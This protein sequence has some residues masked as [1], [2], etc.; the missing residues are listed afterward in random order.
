METWEVVLILVLVTIAVSVLVKNDISVSLIDTL[1]N[2]I[3]QLAILATT[4]LLATVSPAVAIVAI[5]TIVVVYYVRNLAKIQMIEP[6][7]D[8]PRIELTEVKTVTMVGTPQINIVEST[9]PEVSKGTL[10]QSNKAPPAD[11]SDVITTVLGEHVSRPPQEQK[12][13]GERAKLGGAAPFESQP[14]PAHERFENPRGEG[15]IAEA[16]DKQAEFYGDAPIHVDG[17]LG[18]VDSDVFI[19]APAT[20]D[21]FNEALIAPEVRPYNDNQGQY[22]IGETRP[23]TK[24]Q[25][26]ELASFQPGSEMGSNDFSPV[27]VSID[28]K[29]ANMNSAFMPSATAPPNFNNAVPGRA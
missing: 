24:V 1:D 21:G 4:L 2:T 13:I 22:T 8:E 15:F 6:T 16:L 3:F 28:D 5:A 7:S 27:G 12:L 9:P 25:K 11:N 26:Y 29:V 14:P 20:V 19:P 23:Y 17:S 18:S 10:P